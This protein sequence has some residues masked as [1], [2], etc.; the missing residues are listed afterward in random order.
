MGLLNA[1]SYGVTHKV[2]VGKIVKPSVWA[3]RAS[4]GI[5]SLWQVYI[6]PGSEGWPCGPLEYVRTHP[7]F[8]WKD[9]LHGRAGPPWCTEPPWDTVKLETDSQRITM[10]TVSITDW[11]VVL[12]TNMLSLMRVWNW[13]ISCCGCLSMKSVG[14]ILS[15]AKFLLKYFPW[16][17]TVEFQSQCC[18]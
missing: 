3:C 13:A 17:R 1:V 16:V 6:F 9:G 18:N 11:R 2:V 8:D 7:P 15:Q 10:T 14:Q 5:F 4:C 12:V